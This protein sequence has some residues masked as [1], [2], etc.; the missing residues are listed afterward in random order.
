[1][2]HDGLD[3]KGKNIYVFDN[4]SLRLSGISGKVRETRRV[5]DRSSSTPSVLGDVAFPDPRRRNPV[6]TVVR[7]SE[8][9]ARRRSMSETSCWKERKSTSA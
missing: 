1:M 8:F 9:S 3:R 7:P 6:V 2:I 5:E 4:N